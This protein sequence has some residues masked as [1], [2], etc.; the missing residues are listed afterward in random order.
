[1]TQGLLALDLASKTGWCASAPGRRLAYGLL[2]LPKTGDDIGWF[3]EEYQ[4][5]LEKACEEWPLD[6]IIFEEPLKPHGKVNPKNPRQVTQNT[7]ITTLRKLYGLTAATELVARQRGIAYREV[8]LST[9]RKSFLGVGSGR[10]SEEFK[11]MA[12]QMCQQIGLEDVTND[13][14]AE[15]IGLHWHAA[16]ALGIDTGLP[17]QLPALGGLFAGEGAAA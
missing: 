10:K 3:L 15:A 11:R 17:K 4:R 1:M 16:D 7:N 13:N 9:W 2:R 5:W 6:W 8:H 14:T 12:I